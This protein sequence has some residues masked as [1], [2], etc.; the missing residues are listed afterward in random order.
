MRPDIILTR[1]DNELKI[2]ILKASPNEARTGID[3][4]LKS[5]K[6]ALKFLPVNVIMNDVRGR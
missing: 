1:T 5:I 4:A 3:T 2:T 6:L